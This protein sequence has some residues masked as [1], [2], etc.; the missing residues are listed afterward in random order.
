MPRQE[1]DR[2]DASIVPPAVIATVYGSGVK[3]E[4]RFTV[5]KVGWSDQSW[6]AARP[7]K[8]AAAMPAAR[9]VL[10]DM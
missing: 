2:L 3:P 6:V 5:P 4:F 10:K 8:E 9:M 1:E 7:A